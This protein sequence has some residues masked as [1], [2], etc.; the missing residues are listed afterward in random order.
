MIIISVRALARATT[1][2]IPFVSSVSREDE[3]KPR[4]YLIH[5]DETRRTGDILIHKMEEMFLYLDDGLA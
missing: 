3:K 4:G 5:I 2:F 1:C